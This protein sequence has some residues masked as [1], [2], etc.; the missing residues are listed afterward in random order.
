MQTPTPD[1]CSPRCLT[2]EIA[3]ERL[4]KAQDQ[5]EL[6]FDEFDTIE[7]EAAE[8]LGKFTG[9]LSLA[10]L[11]SLSIEAANSLRECNISLNG[12]THLSLPIAQMKCFSGKEDLDQFTT[13]D[14][15]AVRYIF[16]VTPDELE[17][18]LC[19]SLNGLNDIPDTLFRSVN[20]D[21]FAI[22]DFAGSVDKFGFPIHSLS[23]NGLKVISPALASDL[24]QYTGCLRLDGLESLSDEAAEKLRDAF[25]LS[26][27]G[28]KGISTAAFRRLCE[29]TFLY[30]NFPS[31]VF[32][33]E[34]QWYMQQA[35]LDYI[36]NKEAY[37]EHRERQSQY[38]TA[39]GWMRGGNYNYGIVTWEYDTLTCEAARLISGT[40]DYHLSF[41][42]IDVLDEDI[43]RELGGRSR[44][45][46][47]FFARLSFPAL[48]TISVGVA[49]AL[50]DD[51]P[52]GGFGL[53]LDAIEELPDEVAEIL[54]QHSGP[55]SL[56]GLTQL[57]DA[58]AESLSKHYCGDE[59]GGLRLGD[60][61][62]ISV[63]GWRFLSKHPSFCGDDE[64]AE[65]SDEAEQ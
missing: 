30:V 40:Q 58:A 51:G 44:E 23:L 12:L 56:R 41:E 4:A 61:T 29:M 6:A 37:E 48:A 3:R 26:L 35:S 10:T 16:K 34:L 47:G 59:D 31:I 9:R 32:T 22:Y 19:I 43:A 2:T 28:L 14:A 27:E 7:D 52:L 45:F 42:H 38:R 62:L 5:T 64:E 60:Q 55:L 15:D 36:T 63:R 50:I 46:E 13:I 1:R 25:A 53:D 54:G 49:S 39:H 57:S 65:G 17:Y 24:A 33:D 11:K 8:L 18:G 21:R 20:W